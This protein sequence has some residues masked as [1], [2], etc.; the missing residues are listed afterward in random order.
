MFIKSLKLAFI[1]CACSYTLNAQETQNISLQECVEIALA[2]NLDLKAAGLRAETETIQFKQSRNALLPSVNANYNL[3]FSNGRSIDPFTNSYVNEELTYSN[4][5][6]SIIKTLFDGF[7]I[8]NTLKQNRLNMAAAEMEIEEARQNLVLDVTLN[9]LQVLN[10]RELVK[11]AETRLITSKE[12]LNRLQK[13]QDEETGDPVAYHDLQGQ[14]AL[15]QSAVN[16]ANSSLNNALTDLKFLLNTER[17]IQASQL[18]LLLDFEPR[19]KTADGVYEAALRHLA[20]V[21]AKELREEAAAKGVAVARAQYTPQIS[22]FANFGTNYSSAARLFQDAGTQTVQTGDFVT[23]TGTDYAVFT[24]EGLF[25]ALPISYTDQF[26][27]NLNSAAG[28]S[29]SI[30]IFNGFQAKNAVQLQKVNR[31]QASVVLEQTKRALK[32]NIS[33]TYADLQ[34]ASKNYHF[35]EDQVRAYEES[36]RINEVKF[37]LGVSTSV[38]YITSKN[39]LDNARINLTNA[40]YAYLL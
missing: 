1:A 38:A 25:D 10:F 14:V 11:L 2:H 7:I 20:S 5:G 33:K 35:L 19:E 17:S 6:L 15:D 13:L 26:N 21:K 22:L 27:N 36:F 32:Q 8:L 37:N 28:V 29:V 18:I 16:D 39:N 23:V 3:G 31:D 24:Q 4:A 34:A 9:F 12:Q 40:R 30:P